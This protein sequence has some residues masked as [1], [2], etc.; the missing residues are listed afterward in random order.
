MVQLFTKKNVVDASTET[1]SPLLDS[2][3]GLSFQI[4]EGTTD[5]ITTKLLIQMLLGL[6]NLLC[7][8]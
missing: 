1:K 3:G 6:K 4:G 8:V 2:K 7:K 5:L